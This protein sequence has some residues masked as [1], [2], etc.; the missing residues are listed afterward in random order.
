MVATSLVM[1]DKSVRKKSVTYGR[2][3]GPTDG[4]TDGPTYLHLT[5]VGARDACASSSSTITKEDRVDF[6]GD[7]VDLLGDV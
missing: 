6:L 1:V 5:W 2:T 4:R 3:H 7:G